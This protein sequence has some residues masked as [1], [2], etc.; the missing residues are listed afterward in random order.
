MATNPNR[1]FLTNLPIFDEKK[2]D[3]WCKQKKIVFVVGI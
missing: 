3:N 2:Y 1:N